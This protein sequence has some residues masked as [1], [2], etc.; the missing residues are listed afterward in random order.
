MKSYYK[1]LTQ[2]A[3]IKAS[4]DMQRAHQYLEQTMSPGGYICRLRR[5]INSIRSLVDDINL[6]PR[7]EE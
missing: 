3:L 7:D 6:A 1:D 2:E 5:I 4:E